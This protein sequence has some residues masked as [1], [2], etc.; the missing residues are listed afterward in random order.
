MAWRI[1]SKSA[2]DASSNQKAEI[3][4]IN[5]QKR[6]LLLKKARSNLR[7][8]IHRTLS[9]WFT[10]VWLVGCA[11]R[12]GD[13]SLI[14]YARFQL[15][16]SFECVVFFICKWT[17]WR[18]RSFWRSTIQGLETALIISGYD[19]RT[20]IGSRRRHEH[21]GLTNNNHLHSLHKR[22]YKTSQSRLE[23]VRLAKHYHF[24]RIRPPCQSVGQDNM[25]SVI[26][27]GSVYQVQNAKTEQHGFINHD[28]TCQIPQ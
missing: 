11:C 25:L 6:P 16:T 7:R 13:P 26:D 24:R 2:G 28:S 17:A 21:N 1:C 18:L 22:A 9:Q 12:F 14:L 23:R 5:G 27:Y 4:W 3:P 19:I 15:L 20:Q 10:G 8:L